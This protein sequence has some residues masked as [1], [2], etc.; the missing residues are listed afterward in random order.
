M[1]DMQFCWQINYISQCLQ[2]SIEYTINPDFLYFWSWLDSGFCPN[3]DFVQFGILYVRDCVQ[4]LDEL[5]LLR[6]A[7]RKRNLQAIK[8]G[9]RV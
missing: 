9:I 7:K 5:L 1:N 3:R 6:V 4:D 8:W 2:A